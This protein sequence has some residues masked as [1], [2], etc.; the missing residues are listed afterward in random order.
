MNTGNFSWIN[1]KYLATVLSFP[2]LHLNIS[3]SLWRFGTEIRTIKLDRGKRIQGKS[4]MNLSRLVLHGYGALAV[5]FDIAFSRIIIAISAFGVGVIVLT[6]LLIVAKLAGIYHVA[7]GILTLVFFEVFSTLAV[8]FTF[9]FF[10]LILL[11]RINS[12]N[13]QQG[14]KS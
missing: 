9:T 5:Y 12:K 2:E 13:E 14:A 11:L 7:P 10:S 8:L 4:K 1:S 3:A 6:V